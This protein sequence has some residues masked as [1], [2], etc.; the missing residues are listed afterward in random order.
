MTCKQCK[1]KGVLFW[2]L[3]DN[4]AIERCDACDKFPTDLAAAEA[5]AQNAV[6]A[7]MPEGNHA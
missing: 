2:V 4:I 7:E 6:T 1:D 3:A 5:V